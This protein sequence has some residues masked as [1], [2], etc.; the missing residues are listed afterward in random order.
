MPGVP[1]SGG[2]PPKR[3]K[4]RRRRNKPAAGEVTT[5]KAR[6]AVKVRDG[7]PPRSGRGSSTAAWLEY[8]EGIGHDVP[9]GAT[10]GQIIALVDQG[11]P[12]E[13]AE[14]D[15]A[16]REWYRSLADSAQHQFYEPSDWATAK[17]A[18]II[19]SEGLKALREGRRGSGTQLERWQAIATELLTTEGA[20]RRARME[21][22][23]AADEGA[24]EDA[25]EV[26]QLDAHLG[27]LRSV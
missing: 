9:D 19:L 16:A 17:V 11:L 27:R 20:R 23:R 15:P 12:D 4:H 6:G 7:E 5:V 10:R 24:E 1:G 21:I 25:G 3:S 26:L 2:P 18:A 22:E 13:T 8:A 14:W